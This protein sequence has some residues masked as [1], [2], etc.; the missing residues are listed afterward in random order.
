MQEVYKDKNHYGRLDHVKFAAIIIIN[1]YTKTY[2]SST[3]I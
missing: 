2:K 1:K 3:N